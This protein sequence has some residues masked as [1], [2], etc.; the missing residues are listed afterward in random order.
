MKLSFSGKVE[1]ASITFPPYKCL[2]AIFLAL[3]NETPPS[4]NNCS[5]RYAPPSSLR[6]ESE[7]RIVLS[8][9]D[10][11]IRVSDFNLLDPPHW[12]NDKL[13]GVYYE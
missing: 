4:A 2:A 5:T 6:M 12:I 8:Y 7:T 11:L 3:I 13:I 9:H 1:K 10:S